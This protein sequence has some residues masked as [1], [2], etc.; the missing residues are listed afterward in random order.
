[1]WSAAVL[2]VALLALAA[3]SSPEARRSRGSGPGADVGNR[4]A[5]VQLHAGSSPYRNT[6]ALVK[7]VARG[8]GAQRSAPPR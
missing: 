1:M 8:D 3:C 6:P 5:Q 2:V 7:R 4:K